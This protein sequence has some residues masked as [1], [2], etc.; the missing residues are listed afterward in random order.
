ME[1][2]QAVSTEASLDQ[3]VNLAANHEHTSKFS[4]A[5]PFPA[6]QTI[7]RLVILSR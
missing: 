3:L 1:Q 2:R 6:S 5:Q 4:R 7:H